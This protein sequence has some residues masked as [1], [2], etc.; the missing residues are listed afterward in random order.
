MR[1]SIKRRYRGSWSLILDAGYV[2]D[3]T[4]GLQK[5]KQRW[6][7]F[8]G[9]KKQAE[10]K[11]AELVRAANRNELPEPTKATFGEWLDDWLEKA[12]KPRK[13]PGTHATYAHVAEQHIKPSLGAIRLQALTSLDI[14]RYYAGLGLKPATAQLHHAVIHNALAAAQRANL[15]SR[16]VAALVTGKP[17][18]REGH[19]DVLDH[20]WR[21]D[22]ARTFLK[23]TK[24][25]G[26]QWAAF[27]ALALDSGMRKGELCGLQW[28]D[29]D[30]EHRQ[31]AIQRQLLKPGNPPTFGP[32][33]NKTPRTIDV[34]VETAELLR[35]HK[36]RQAE[37]KLA[38]RTTYHDN[39]LVFAKDWADCTKQHDVLGDALQSNNLGQ[40]V[41]RK[42]IAAAGVRAIK[43]HGLRHTS[44]TLLLQAGVPAHVVQ[45]RLG[46]KRIE[47]T[48][49]IYGHVLPAMQQDAAA[50]LAALLHG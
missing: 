12:V 20:C 43:L 41:Y 10:D 37:I 16:N 9:T 38:N 21:H 44:A 14:E 25:A 11:L 26:P 1:G 49:G 36:A 45:R 2:T 6:I 13:A 24:E 46:H 32:V 22:E 47:M 30:F 33:K 28:V 15:V 27:F 17:R 50:K 40:R 4:T 23:A 29:V 3:P 19:Q 18:A 42:L 31:I 5:R 7:T 39:G 35:R 48:L 34:S 8:R